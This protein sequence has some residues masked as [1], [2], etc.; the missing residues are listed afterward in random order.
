MRTTLVCISFLLVVSSACTSSQP[1]SLQ[2]LQPAVPADA[3][4][5]ADD[6]GTPAE[7]FERA[8][9]SE[10]ELITF[11]RRMP[12]GADLHNHVSGATYSD[13]V[14][15]SAVANGL[16]YNLSQDKF[17]RDSLASGVI[18]ST[19]ELVANAVYLAQFLNTFSMRGWYPNTT[20][21]HDHFFATFSLIGSA[22]RSSV[23]MVAEIVARNRYEN[24]Q[25]L[26]LMMTSVPGNVVSKFGGTLD[27]FDIENLGDAYEK[28]KGLID[29]ESLLKDI[30]DYLDKRDKSIGEKLELDY[31][32][33]GND[34]DLVIRYIPQL[35][36]TRS[37]KDF[38]IG[39]VTAMM[40]ITR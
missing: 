31:S 16:N 38:F 11:L 34:G 18:V 17:T 20:N 19:D 32:I 7:R 10:P 26:E 12:K 40:A 4:F 2:P 14:L 36:R 5:W 28:V 35:H 6:V 27:T 3:P 9:Q 15:D 22:K 25:Y 39:A 8:K 23:D 29:K 33:T 13:Y 1:L 24:V 21:G 37:L 30:E